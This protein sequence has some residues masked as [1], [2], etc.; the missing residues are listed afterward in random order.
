MDIVRLRRVRE[1]L[2]A[3][4]FNAAAA[5]AAFGHELG[6]TPRPAERPLQERRLAEVEP[7]L[8]TVLGFFVL[9]L[10]AGADELDRALA[11][12]SADDLVELGLAAEHDGAMR[13]TVRILTHDQFLIAA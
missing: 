5:A 9:E 7:R 1:G 4:G 10:P 6:A 8:A 11:P 12:A 3:A 13:A 2:R